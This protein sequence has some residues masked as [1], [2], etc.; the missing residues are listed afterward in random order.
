MLGV[1]VPCFYQISQYLFFGQI[2][3]PAAHHQLVCTRPQSQA[4]S[5]MVKGPSDPL[6]EYWNFSEKVFQM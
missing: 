2:F 3:Y 4:A 5:L 6:R 1:T